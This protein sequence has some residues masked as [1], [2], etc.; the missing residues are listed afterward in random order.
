MCLILDT[1][2]YGDFLNPVN[3]DM[4]PIRE[5]IRTKNGKIVYAPTEKMEKELGNHNR[6]K[7]M[8]YEYRQ[9]GRLK[10]IDR[11]KVNRTEAELTGLS[12]N[13]GHIVALALAAEVKLLVSEDKKLHKDFK[14]FVNGKIYQNKAHEPLLK[15]DICP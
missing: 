12:S 1:N 8:F 7:R 9:A 3:S 10:I 2:K 14:K 4:Q 13:D 5:W 15:R 11:E 6:M